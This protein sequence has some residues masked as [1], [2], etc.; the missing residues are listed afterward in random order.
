[1]KTDKEYFSDWEGYAFGYGYGTG[2]PVILPALKEFLLLCNS[3][4]SPR[5][6]QYEKL[7]KH[8]TPTVAWLLINILCQVDIIEY[9][10]SPRYGWLTQKGERLRE[11]VSKYTD[12][13]LI[14]ICC[15][16]DEEYIHCYPDACN[17]GPN[18]Y[19]K[20]RICQNP[21]WLEKP[22]EEG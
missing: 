22:S 7:E 3:E 20:G 16:H 5:S 6:Y 8:L 9:G 18:G 12:D 10:T 15:T 13:Q 4:D 14:E 19:E 17:C 21:F 11:F 1:M 2:E